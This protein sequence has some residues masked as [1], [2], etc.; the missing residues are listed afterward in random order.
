MVDSSFRVR[1]VPRPTVVDGRG[2]PVP[3]AIVLNIHFP[4]ETVETPAGP[5]DV[6][7]GAGVAKIKVEEQTIR[8]VT[9]C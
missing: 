7:A 6:I 1:V 3:D 5:V 4:G 2:V 9:L 8:G